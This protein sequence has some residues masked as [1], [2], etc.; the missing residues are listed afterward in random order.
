MRAGVQDGFDAYVHARG[1]AWE[2][3]AFALTG[4]AGHAQ[5]LVQTV[6]VKMYRAWPR[7]TAAENPDAYV[8]RMMT[9]SYLDDRR[10]RRWS[11]IAMAD[12]P[13]IGSSPD[14]AAAVLAIQDLRHGLSALTPAQRAVLVLRHVEDLDDDEI[15]AVLGSSVTTV[16]THASRGRDRFRAALTTSEEIR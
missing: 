4:D 1:R 7:V 13:E 10:R 2:R 5:D 8:R 15:A 11:E 9:R 3:Y 12:P 6:L 14:P 16:R